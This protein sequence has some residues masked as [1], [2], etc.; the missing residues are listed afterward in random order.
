MLHYVIRD[1]DRGTP[2][3]QREIEYRTSEALDELTNGV[4]EQKHS[5]IVEGTA[6]AIIKL[7]EDRSHTAA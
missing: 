7:W 2:I 4:H 3:V 5:I 6:M 1:V